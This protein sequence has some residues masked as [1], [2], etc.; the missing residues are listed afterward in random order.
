MDP[1]AA[2]G[3]RARSPLDGLLAFAEALTANGLS[4]ADVTLSF[5][6]QSLGADREGLEWTYDAATN[7]ESRY[8]SGGDF[9]LTVDGESLVGG[10]MPRTTL[11][12]RYNDLAN[13]TDDEISLTTDTIRP[14]NR[15]GGSSEATQAAAVALLSDLSRER[16]P[17]RL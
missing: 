14:E 13:C 3:L 12:I 17:F 2:V 4:V 15:S 10:R 1:G 16:G 6:V 7:V 9:I 11:R 5:G 8:Y